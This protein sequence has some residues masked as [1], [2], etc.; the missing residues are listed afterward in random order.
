[1]DRKCAPGSPWPTAKQT[2]EDG[3][4]ALVIAGVEVSGR[5]VLQPG[6]PVVVAAI[7]PPS[8]T[9]K[10]VVA[11]GQL[12]PR[13]GATVA[14]NCQSHW[15]PKL[16]VRKIVESSPEAKQVLGLTQLIPVMLALVKMV[17]VRHLNPPSV[18]ATRPPSPAA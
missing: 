11:L 12:M 15:V 5:T 14:P 3:Q 10:H 16:V 6:A 7:A 2:F 1:V 8:P 13:N 18:E 9:A 17:S 4:L